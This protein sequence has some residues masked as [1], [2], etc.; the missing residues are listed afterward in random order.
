MTEVFSKV[1]ENFSEALLYE[2]T[3]MKNLG[4]LANNGALIVDTTPYTGRSP[5]DKFI[6]LDENTENI[7][8][9]GE[10]NRPFDP[11]KFKIL[12]EG[13]LEYLSTKE[14]Y[15]QDLFAGNHPDYRIGIRLY[16]ESPW[17]ALFARNMFLR[18]TKEDLINFSP[19]LTIYHAPFFKA[20]PSKHGTRSEV[21]IILNLTT[22]EILIGGTLY[23]GEIKKSVF[24]YLNYYYP[25]KGVLSMHCGANV[26]N[27]GD[28]AL[29][30]GLSGTGK[31]SLSTDPERPLIGDDEHGWADDGVFNF[32]GGCYAKVIRI[33]P[34]KEP[35]IY[36]ASTRFGAILENV[37]FDPETREVNFN[38]SEK[39]ENTRSSYPIHFLDN[40][41]P[42]GRAGHPKNIFFLALDAYGVLPPIAKLEEEQIRTYFLAGYTSKIA[43]TERGITEPQPTFSACFGAP[44]LPLKPETYADMLIER[45]KKH[46][47]SVWLV[48]TGWIEGPYGEGHRID[49]RY[50]RRLISAALNG[51]IQEFFRDEIFGFLVPKKVEGIPDKI[52][53]PSESWKN[54]EAY[55]ESA[56][57]IKNLIEEKSKR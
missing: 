51:E 7:I 27:K 35:G 24:T 43:G 18:P 22:K 28:V 26:G 15:S 5:K 3:I 19:T 9:W 10:V 33:D 57:K 38:S 12:K 20:D 8:W 47:V 40:I 52:L 34:E 29:F 17:H 37:V 39:T 41:V 13:L 25:L 36:K 50:T 42:E 32:E 2:E 56:L 30:F 1:K 49:I 4:Y 31:T 48:N 6:V 11:E 54:K 16:T 14:I 45:I 46:N 23:A 53:I 55:R 44:F 21:F